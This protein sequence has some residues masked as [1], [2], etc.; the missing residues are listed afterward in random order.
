[1]KYWPIAKSRDNAGNDLIFTSYEGCP[2]EE[3][4]CAT[5]DL[6]EQEYDYELW[7]MKINVFDDSMRL[8]DVLDVEH[9][10]FVKGAS[11]KQ[12]VK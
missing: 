6:W 7:D 4:A 3:T 10:Y 12:G 8:V 11:I 9:G 1:M 5:F 2:T